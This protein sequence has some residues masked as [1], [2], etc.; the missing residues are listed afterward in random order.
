[1]ELPLEEYLMG[2]ISAE[3]PT[4]FSP[5]AQKAQAVAARTFSLT[6]KTPRFVQT[7]PAARHGFLSM[8]PKIASAASKPR[9]CFPQ[10]VMP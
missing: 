9:K 3:M 6:P 1:M 4:D 8:K 5:E 10:Q 7:T 2:V